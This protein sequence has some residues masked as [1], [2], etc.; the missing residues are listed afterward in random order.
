MLGLAV[1]EILIDA[2][3]KA[4]EGELARL[5]NRLVRGGTCAGWPARSISAH[6]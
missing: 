5:Y 2:H 1:A 4:S 3:P 6:I